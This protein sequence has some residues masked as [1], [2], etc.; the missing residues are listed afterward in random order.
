MTRPITVASYNIHGCVGKDRARDARRVAQ[1]I[2]EL[3]SDIV[4]LQEV[5]SRAGGSVEAMQKDY[6]AQATGLKA[7]AGPA[8]QRHDRHYGNLL[9][10]NHTIQDVRRLDLSVR[11]QEPRGALDVD[12]EIRGVPTRAIVTHFGLGVSERR[13]QAMRLLDMIDRYDDGRTTIVMGDFN[14]WFPLSRSL[15]WLRRRFGATPAPRTYPAFLPLLSLDRI[16]VGPPGALLAVETHHA[17]DARICSDHLPLRAQIS[18]G[19]PTR[20]QG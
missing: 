20:R 8:I 18:L 14:E 10:T 7:I 3:Q 17:G 2:C 6:L 1:V 13:F 11:G 4:G 12:L 9:L 16:W 5:D 19:V 15:G